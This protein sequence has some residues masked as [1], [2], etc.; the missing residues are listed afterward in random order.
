MADPAVQRLD[1]EIRAEETR[2]GLQ[3]RPRL[4]LLQEQYLQA[5]REG[6][7][8]VLYRRCPG[9]HGRWG[10]ICVLA[11]GH[12]ATEPHWGVTREDEPI[13]WVGTAPDDD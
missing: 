5:E 9:K 7:L 1:K 3:L 10:R 11:T 4:Q 8:D 6:D 12:G 13:A 2:L